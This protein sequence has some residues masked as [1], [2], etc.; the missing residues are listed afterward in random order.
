MSTKEKINDFFTKLPFKGLAE[1]I[2]AETRAKVPM[3][4]KAILFANQ[5]VCG[6]ALVLLITIIANSGGKKSDGASSSKIPSDFVGTWNC[7]DES[8]T[9]VN[10]Y[11]RTGIKRFYVLEIGNNGTI[12]IKRYFFD[13]NEKSPYGKIIIFDNSKIKKV[14]RSQITF[15]IVDIEDEKEYNDAIIKLVGQSLIWDYWNNYGWGTFTK[16]EPNP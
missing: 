2:P 1:K 15:D 5:I 16:G 3:L 4:D 7:L 11:N 12:L 6:L 8:N 14:S 10:L 13:Y 9:A